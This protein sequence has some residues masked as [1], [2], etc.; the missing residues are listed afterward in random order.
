MSS[1]FYFDKVSNFYKSEYKDKLASHALNL[2]CCTIYFYE[3]DHRP[4]IVSNEATE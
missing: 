4:V 3:G 1:Y 2:E